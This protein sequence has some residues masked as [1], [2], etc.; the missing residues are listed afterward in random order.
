[1]D[2]RALEKILRRQ[3]PTI[4]RER[5]AE[6][7][8]RW[9]DYLRERLSPPSRWDFARRSAW[10]R[11]Y[12]CALA[13][14][15][16]REVAQALIVELWYC[17]NQDEDVSRNWT[18][19]TFI[20]FGQGDFEEVERARLGERIVIAQVE[21]AQRSFVVPSR[22]YSPDIELPYR[23]RHFAAVQSRSVE[24]V[25]SV[26]R[27]IAAPAAREPAREVPAFSTDAEPGLVLDGVAPDLA[28]LIRSF[29]EQLRIFPALE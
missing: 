24:R 19:L 16:A 22:H 8:N 6:A 11:A 3:N 29:A 13:L 27:V 9:H 21:R 18:R 4:E 2:A 17:E 5:A 1:M 23:N 28:Q 26:D 14:G 7:G 25:L 15:N 10:Q 20:R 12:D